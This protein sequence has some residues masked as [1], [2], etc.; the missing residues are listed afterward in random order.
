MLG[1]R[2]QLQIRFSSLHL[3]FTS[4]A[5]YLLL[6]YAVRLKQAGR[7]PLAAAPFSISHIPLSPSIIQRFHP[8]HRIHIFSSHLCFLWCR[9]VGGSVVILC[10]L[11]H[12]PALTIND[13]RRNEIR[14]PANIINPYQHPHPTWISLLRDRMRPQWPLVGRIMIHCCTSN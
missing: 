6:C 12:E 4:S 1:A 2:F 13:E 5:S 10:A 9:W 14:P 3:L 11:L 7:L 8:H